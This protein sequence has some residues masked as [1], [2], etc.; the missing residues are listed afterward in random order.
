LAVLAEAELKFYNKQGVSSAYT[1]QAIRI[2]IDKARSSLLN[3]VDLPAID[4]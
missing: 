2:N 4:F 1:E 3:F